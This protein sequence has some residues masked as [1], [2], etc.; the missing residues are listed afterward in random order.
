VSKADDYRA[1]AADCDKKAEATKDVQEQ[2]FYR[3]AAIGWRDLA[4]RTER[5]L[6]LGGNRAALI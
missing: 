1:Y 4:L 3:E 6:L 2:Q 5:H